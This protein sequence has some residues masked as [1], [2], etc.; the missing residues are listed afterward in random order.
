MLLDEDPFTAIAFSC[1]LFLSCIDSTN[2]GS[3]VD[4][5]SQT[6]PV[7]IESESHQEG[8]LEN[9]KKYVCY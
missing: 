9:M 8:K 1:S 6:K 3:Q 2:V 4:Q 5:S 7:T